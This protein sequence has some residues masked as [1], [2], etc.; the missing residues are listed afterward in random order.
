M[1][2]NHQPN[3]RP[4]FQTDR[5]ILLI[6]AVTALPFLLI[7]MPRGLTGTPPG[8]AIPAAGVMLLIAWGIIR[9]VRRYRRVPAMR[10]QAVRRI[11]MLL[12]YAMLLSDLFH[13]QWSRLAEPSNERHET[14]MSSTK[15]T[16]HHLIVEDT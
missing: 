9:E 8:V 6:I 2:H 15:V 13:L 5:Q 12:I 10:E 1:P 4:E 7:S 14:M 3:K 11:I 16:H